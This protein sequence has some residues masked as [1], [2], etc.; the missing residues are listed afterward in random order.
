M[1][2]EKHNR[3]KYSREMSDWDLGH[4]L[5]LPVPNS[6]MQ[7]GHCGYFDGEGNWNPIALLPDPESVSAAGLK[8]MAVKPPRQAPVDDVIEWGPKLSSSVNSSDAKLDIGAA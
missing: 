5:Y 3:A 4:A 6:E 2:P 8:P 7:L 1:A